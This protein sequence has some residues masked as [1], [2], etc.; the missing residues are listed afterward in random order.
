MKRIPYAID[1]KTSDGAGVPLALGAC[2]H[3]TVIL[4]PGKTATTP[5]CV[6]QLQVSNSGAALAD[7]VDGDFVDYGDPV[8]DG[9]A[10]PITLELEAW[11]YLR[12]VRSASMPGAAPSASWAGDDMRTE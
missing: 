7:L 10:T 11:T 3:M 2:I 6:L 12:V 4:R 9:I 8:D 5:D 1:I